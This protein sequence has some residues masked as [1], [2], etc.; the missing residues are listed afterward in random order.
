MRDTLWRGPLRMVVWFAL[1]VCMMLDGAVGSYMISGSDWVSMD[2]YGRF[3]T[4]PRL[5][6]AEWA[7]AVIL[8]F[9]QAALIFAA[10]RL[11]KSEM[12]PSLFP[13]H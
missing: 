8:L 2:L 6:V 4:R 9:V 7:F 10:R 12:E 1:A 13:R 3:S 11:R 5:G